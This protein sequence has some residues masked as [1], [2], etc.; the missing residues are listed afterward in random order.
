MTMKTYEAWLACRSCGRRR[1][2]SS[3]SLGMRCEQCVSRDNDRKQRAIDAKLA[4]GKE[5]SMRPVK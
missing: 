5:R 3:F 4:A 1:P 2:E